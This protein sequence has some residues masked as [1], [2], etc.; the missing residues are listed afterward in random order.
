[1]NVGIGNKAS[2]FHFWKYI[3]YIFDIVLNGFAEV[4]SDS[5]KCTVCKQG[6]SFSGNF[7]MTKHAVIN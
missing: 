3:N 2:Q 5:Y 7:S 1:M 6:K 4:V